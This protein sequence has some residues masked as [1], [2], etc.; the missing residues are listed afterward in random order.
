MSHKPVLSINS[1]EM[2]EIQVIPDISAALLSDL[3]SGATG[4]TD[5]LTLP[6]V[7]GLTSG[8]QFDILL[9]GLINKPLLVSTT[10]SFWIRINST[11]SPNLSISL[12]VGTITDRVLELRGALSLRA[13]SS[14]VTLSGHQ[15]S[16]TTPLFA[17]T[18]A[19]GVAPGAITSITLGMTYS[20]TGTGN[21]F[22]AQLARIRMCQ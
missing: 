13:S 3:S 15:E 6:I 17:A 4:D 21:C 12:G 16:S 5:L 14:F 1:I 22:T 10:L 8:D 18:S 11:K 9:S 2:S 7:G 20:S 19:V